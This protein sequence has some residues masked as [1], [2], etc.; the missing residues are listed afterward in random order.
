MCFFFFLGPVQVHNPGTVIFSL[1]SHFTGPVGPTDLNGKRAE[2]ASHEEEDE[3]DCPVFHPTPSP[4]I[5]LSKEEGGGETED[6]F[7]PSQEQGKDFHM[8]KEEALWCVKMIR[9]LFWR[10]CWTRLKRGNVNLENTN[11]GRRR[12]RSIFLWQTVEGSQLYFFPWW[13]RKPTSRLTLM[14]AGIVIFL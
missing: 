12:K 10:T 7:F 1:L 13:L 11:T 2:R 9:D 14:K 8:S 4:S 5:H 3:R 6:V